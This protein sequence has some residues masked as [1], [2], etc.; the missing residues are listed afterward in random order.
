MQATVYSYGNNMLT[1][2][3]HLAQFFYESLLVQKKKKEAKSH[4]F[5]CKESDSRLNFFKKSFWL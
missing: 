5:M 1:Q 3:Y 4:V 2:R